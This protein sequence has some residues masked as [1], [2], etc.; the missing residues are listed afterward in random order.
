[1]FEFTQPK[2]SLIELVSTACSTSAK[3]FTVHCRSCSKRL[4]LGVF[5]GFSF[6][7]YIMILNFLSEE[8]SEGAAVWLFTGIV[9]DGLVSVIGTLDGASTSLEVTGCSNAD[10][11]EDCSELTVSMRESMPGCL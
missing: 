7:P 10:L 1:M 2:Q 11:S 5:G 8:L 9:D 4:A 3:A 6:M